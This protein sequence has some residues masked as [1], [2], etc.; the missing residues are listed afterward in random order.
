M[1]IFTMGSIIGGGD[2][3]NKREYYGAQKWN[4]VPVTYEHSFHLLAFPSFPGKLGKD[5]KNLGARMYS[6][7]Y[8][9]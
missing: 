4:P 6:V 9:T 5:N 2:T 3:L 8:R 1:I 7:Q